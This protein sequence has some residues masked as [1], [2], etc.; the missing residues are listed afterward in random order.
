MSNIGIKE[1]GY[2]GI[3]FAS[4]PQ[5][6]KWNRPLEICITFLPEFRF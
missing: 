1:K 6:M 5:L 2:G 4:R 3:K